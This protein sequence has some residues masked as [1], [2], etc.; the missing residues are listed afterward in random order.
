[1]SD[2]DTATERLESFGV[3]FLKKPGDA[4]DQRLNHCYALP[5]GFDV[6]KVFGQSLDQTEFALDLDG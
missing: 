5:E 1:M 2:A 6:G 3:D 4:V